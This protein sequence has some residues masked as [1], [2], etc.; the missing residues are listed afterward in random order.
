VQSGRSFQSLDVADATPLLQ[1][2]RMSEV[3]E[4][5]P[6]ASHRGMSHC[7]RFQSSPTIATTSESR[8]R[9]GKYLLVSGRL[10]INYL[11]IS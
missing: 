10:V 8:I 7:G 1:A 9:N 6:F 11:M 3:A 5:S 2:L 4:F